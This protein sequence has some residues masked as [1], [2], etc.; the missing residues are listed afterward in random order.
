[1]LEFIVDVVVPFIF[2]PMGLVF[3]FLGLLTAYALHSF[4]LSYQPKQI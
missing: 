4:F 1:M 3:L 2:A